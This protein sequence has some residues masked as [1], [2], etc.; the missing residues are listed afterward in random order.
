MDDESVKID[1]QDS[2]EISD[3]EEMQEN[4]NE[5]SQENKI[6]TNVKGGKKYYD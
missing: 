6:K 4:L 5:E 2:G 3:L 1:N